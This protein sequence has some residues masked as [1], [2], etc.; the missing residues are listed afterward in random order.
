MP[1][2]RCPLVK[3]AENI[4]GNL[5]HRFASHQRFSNWALNMIQRRHS[6]QQGSIFFKQNPVES[7]LTTDELCDKASNNI[8]SGFMSKLSRYASNI[9]GSAAYCHNVSEDFWKQLSIRRV[10][11]QFFTF[12]AADMYWP[13][14]HSLFNTQT[15]QLTDEEGR[16]SQTTHTLLIGFLLNA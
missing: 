13:E 11:L 1:L 12:S 8:S 9:T 7:H 2:E 5:I 16:M 3:F 10:F 14:L 6:L 4:D 15:G